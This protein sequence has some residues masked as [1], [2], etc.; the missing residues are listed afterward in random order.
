MANPQSFM[1]SYVGNITTL[2]KILEDLRTQNDMLVQDPTLKSRYFEPPEPTPPG[3]FA[4]SGTA[5]R[6]D[7]TEDDVTN[8]ESAIVQML[9]TFDSGEPPQ[10]SY[11]YKMMP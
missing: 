5:P 3:T 8:A 4:P 9:F 10:K 2:I 11:L 6:T 7:I 1:N